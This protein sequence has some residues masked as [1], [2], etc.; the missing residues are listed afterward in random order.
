[1]RF[2]L[3]F[4]LL[5]HFSKFGFSQERLFPCNREGKSGYCNELGEV[6][7]PCV[8]AQTLPFDGPLAAVEINGIWWMIHRS[9]LLRFN[10]HIYSSDPPPKP[11][12]G[13]Y[14]VQYFDPIFSDV[15]EYYNR[16]GLPVKPLE[17]GNP[18]MD[19]TAYEIFQPQKAITIA[20]SKLGTPYGQEGLDCS[21]FIRFIFNSFGIVLPFYTYEI[22][23]RGRTIDLKEARPGDLV[24]FTGSNPADRKAGHIGMI[25]EGKGNNL[26][27][28]HASSSKGVSINLLK[29]TY[30]QARFLG[31]R[32][33]FD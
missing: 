10:T 30:Y 2:A 21:G 14:K 13:L 1:M 3:I 23:E 11:E 12:K 32:R 29:D 22:A 28:I 31:F 18:Y 26:Q 16:N 24:F 6:K 7:I 19:T 27:F 20:K 33:I 15:T 17:N 8:Y 25:I 5:I 9:G 4:I